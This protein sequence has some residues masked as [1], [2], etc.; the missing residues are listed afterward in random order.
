MGAMPVT[1]F[2]QKEQTQTQLKAKSSKKRPF[3]QS[4][5]DKSIEKTLRKTKDV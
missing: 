4:S 2:Q 1:L 5:K 3:L